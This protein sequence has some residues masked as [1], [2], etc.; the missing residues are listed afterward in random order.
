MVNHWYFYGFDADFGPFYI[1]FC[2]YFPFTGQIYLNG[3]EYAKRQC[4]KTGI[5]FTALDSAFGSAADPAAVQKICDDLTDQEIYRLPASGWPGCR[6]R[7]PPRTSRLT[8]AGSCP[9]S[10]W[11]SPPPWRWTGRSAGGS[12]SSS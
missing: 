4:A 11:S 1:K 6:T 3:H 9:S 7:S 12:S 10:R 5:A 2:G 8:T